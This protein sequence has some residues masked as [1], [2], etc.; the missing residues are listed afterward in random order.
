MQK[1][2]FV[3]GE[4]CPLWMKIIGTFQSM[5]Q[6]FRLADIPSYGVVLYFWDGS[7]SSFE[8][9]TKLNLFLKEHRIALF[10]VF[11]I[12]D[13]GTVDRKELYYCNIDLA[14]HEQEIDLFQENLLRYSQIVDNFGEDLVWQDGLVGDRLGMIRLRLCKEVLADARKQGSWIGVSGGVVVTSSLPTRKDVVNA[15]HVRL[16]RH[17][18]RLLV[19]DLS[20]GIEGPP[21]VRL[22]K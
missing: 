7:S 16:G 15:F 4:I 2:T 19:F 12:K 6:G 3:F 17:G 10:T 1:Q 8:S 11:V 13:S 5:K 22:R 21:P 18:D 9:F 14:V 20:H